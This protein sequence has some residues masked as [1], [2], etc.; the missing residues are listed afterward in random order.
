[1][2]KFQYVACEA[3]GQQVTGVLEAPSRQGAL[4]TLASQKLFPLR[5]SQAEDASSAG[6]FGTGRRVS[7]RHLVV[8]YRQLADLLKAGVP[9]LRSLEL[10][11]RLSGQFKLRLVLQEVREQVADGTRLADAMSQYPKV[12]SPL[13]VS[14]I[15]A[16]EEGS[17]LE[18]VLKRIA[19][20][21]E[22]QQ[23][24]K[25][26]V[27]GAMIYPV[28]LLVF[29]TLVVAGMLVFF[30]PKFQP[31]LDRLREQ[32]DLPWATTTLLAVSNIA[33]QY[34]MI[35]FP[36]IIVGAWL[37]FSWLKT[38][39]G[40]AKYDALLLRVYGL[41]SII[42]SL[43]IAR[44]CRILGTLLDN[45]VPILRSLNIAKHA[46][47]NVVLSRAIGNAAQNISEGRSLAAPLASSGQF[48]EEVVEMISVGEEA[49]NLE[50]VLIDVADAMERRTNRMLDTFVRMLEPLLLTLMAGL[51]LFVVAALLWPIMQTSTIL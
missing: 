39:S 14:M 6:R 15:K 38:E 44:F 41:G 3:S 19:N 46:T 35:V 27:M 25:A 4:S 16:G 37:L 10:L 29:M 5:V 2:P 7:G 40:Q 11:E 22:H 26:R 9:L 50:Q 20:F 48:P 13:A 18:D 12:F 24:L 30:I 8:F 36:A 32:G 42:R 1:M 31:I 45:G 51:V 34:W 23:E 33:Q 28:F 43:A 21:T 49:N 17:F 47:G